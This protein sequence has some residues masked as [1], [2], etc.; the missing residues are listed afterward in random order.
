MDIFRDPDEAIREVE[1]NEVR[2][3]EQ[4]DIEKVLDE[5]PEDHESA[6]RRTPSRP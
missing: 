5:S 1:Q 3:E 4:A 2:R 6:T